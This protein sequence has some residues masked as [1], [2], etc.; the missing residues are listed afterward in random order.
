MAKYLVV[1]DEVQLT[2]A[3][4]QRIASVE[5]TTAKV[6]GARLNMTVPSPAVYDGTR[7]WT[8]KSC[9]DLLNSLTRPDW[10]SAITGPQNGTNSEEQP[11]ATVPSCGFRRSRDGN[12]KLRQTG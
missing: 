5:I 1:P 4:A 6:L 11:D 12:G 2:T 9:L 8:G 10:L 3:A 7:L